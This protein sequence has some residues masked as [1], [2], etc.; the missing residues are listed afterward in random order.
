MEKQIYK[1]LCCGEERESDKII[2]CPE[3]GYKMLPTPFLRKEALIKEIQNFV[4]LNEVNKISSKDIF[5]S[6]LEKDEKRFPDFKTIQGYVC[7]SRTAEKFF[8]NLNQSLNNIKKHV[9]ESFANTYKCEL[10]VIDYRVQISDEI[11]KGILKDLNIKEEIQDVEIPKISLTF[12]ETPNKELLNQADTLIDLLLKLSA[13]LQRFIAVNNIYGD[14]FKTKNDGS[15]YKEGTDDIE[16][17][18]QEIYKVNKVREKN[19]VVDLFDDGDENLKEMSKTIWCGIAALMKLPLLRKQYLY[20]LADGT[21]AENK[22]IEKII[23]SILKNKYASIEKIILSPDFLSDLTEDSV[24]DLYNKMLAKDTNGYMGADKNNLV[25]VGESEKRLNELIGLSS[26]KSSIQ[27]IKAYAKNN[28]GS[29]DL[30]LHMCFYGNPGTGK[31]EVARIMA[32]ILYENKIL[33]TKNVIETDR[34]GMVGQ[35]VGETPQKVM[36]VIQKAMGGVLFIDEAYALVQGTGQSHYDYGH[37]AVATLIKAMEDYRGKFCVIMAGYRNQMEEM[38]A[39]NP[40]FSS[41]IQFKLDF[42]NY[43]RDELSRIVELQLFKRGYTITEQAKSRLLDI[44]DV[45]RKEENFANAREVRNILDQAIMCQNLRAISKDEK[46]IAIVDINKYIKDSNLK[47][48]SDSYDKHILTAEEELEKLIGLDSVK[49]TLKKI[50][51]YAKRNVNNT[52]LNLHMCF[53]GNPGTGKTEVARILSRILYE[54][55]VLKEA[56]LVETD[57]FGLMGQAVGETGPKTLAKIKDALGGVLFIDEAYA[58]SG[59]NSGIKGSGSYGSEAIAVLLKEM[60][61]KRGQFCTILAG[62]KDKMQDMIATNPGFESRIQFALD[63]PDYTRDELCGI[64]KAMA[65]KKNYTISEEALSRILDITDYERQ[66]PNYANARSARNILDQVILNQNVRTDDSLEGKDLI[67]LEDVEDYI[68]DKG[69]K[70]S[71]AKKEAEKDDFD[72]AR[73]KDE[74]YEFDDEV[75]IDYIKQAVISISSENSQGTGFLISK[76]GYCLT[77]AHCIESDG[78]SQRAR[79]SMLLANG[80]LF[81]IYSEFSLI[82]KDTINDIALLKLKEQMDYPLLPLAAFSY[83]YDPLKKFIMAG[84]PFGGEVYQEISFI[85][86]KVASVN[87]IEDRKTVFADMFG[88]PGSSGSPVIDNN[89][90]KVI[91]IFWGGINQYESGEKIPCFTPVDVIWDFLSRLGQ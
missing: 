63:F 48:P 89:K 53:Y 56:K 81:N 16:V 74:Y 5:V 79:V 45:K 90:S 36:G 20:T 84:F 2:S 70:I 75:D 40:G 24:F 28:K 46:E 85:E 15:K 49:K 10:K 17:L 83:K 82:G 47:L 8:S 51:A 23:V 31:T 64:I 44:T 27:K 80:K 58:L 12:R 52:D 6:G 43:S 32:G 72:L 65:L 13:K 60:E 88:K 42:P 87:N 68:N 34:S 91:G 50:K 7:S 19:Y 57:S 86:G 14:G 18:T 73:L 33:P 54:A 1:C 69:L 26:I 4:L 41:R 25:I 22:E 38:I 76:N 35:F 55:G 67:L 37:E 59:N 30:N 66:K 11:L 21:V 77:C 29:E 61:D 62:Y 78:S 71:A 9:H 39:T 3:C